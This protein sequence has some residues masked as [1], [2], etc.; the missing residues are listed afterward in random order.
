MIRFEDVSV[1][2]DGAAEPTVRG[3]DFEVPEGE[4]VLLVGP[5]GVGKSTLLGAVSGLVPHFTGGTLRGR[6]T[7]AG[8]DTRTHKPR[9][10]AD[11]V[12]TVG[13]D[14]LVPLR[15]GHRRGRTR[16]RH[17]V[18]GPGAGRDAPP[19]RGDPRPARPGRPARPPDRH[20]LRRPAAAGRDRLGAHPAPPGPG[21][22]RADLRAR[23]GRRRGGP[24][25]PAAAGPRPRH[26]RPDGRAPP[27]ARR[28]VR[29]PGRPAAR[30]GRR[31]GRSAPR[32]RS[33]PSPRC[34]RRWWPWA[35]WPAG[36]RCRCRCATRGAGPGPCGSGWPARAPP[37][38]RRPGRHP[39]RLRTA[40]PPHRRRRPAAPDRHAADAPPS[41]RRASPPRRR[42]AAAAGPRRT[43]TPLRHRRRPRRVAW[44]SGAA[45]SRRCAGVDL[46][47]GARRDHR[48]H[49]PQRR[50]E[51]DAARHPRRPGRAGRR[52]GPG[53]RRGPAPHRARATS[54]AASDSYRRSRATC[55]TPT[56]SPPSA[57][58]PTADAG[59]APGTCRALVSELLPGI[60]RRH[61]PPRPLRGP[62]ARARAGRRPDRPPAAA[63]PRRA[64][65]RPGLRGEG[66]AGRPCCAGWPPTGTPSCWPPTTWNWPPSSPTGW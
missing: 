56:R 9:E 1:T 30:P 25:R 38:A 10:L 49:G 63:A 42:R 15:D 18:V 23:P 33:W 54:C 29:R 4:L 32:P 16:L 48:A 12:G 31:P 8:R 24:R 34:T 58:P 28:P 64:D 40:G 53:R 57:R 21:P 60:A 19:R 55:C 14:P 6:V 52:H 5:S 26:D 27:G 36:P 2:Y 61:P 62:A 20:P 43:R 50:R 46:T 13:Q 3:V 41:A 45:A 7:V 11:V 47:V 66:P 51:V 37:H 65:P 59:A 39:R 17:G 22:R 35:G 44:P